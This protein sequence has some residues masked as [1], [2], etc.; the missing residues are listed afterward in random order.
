MG[1]PGK[2][3]VDY[4]SH[5][6]VAGK[7][8][9]I[10]EQRYGDKGYVFYFKLQEW[11]GRTEGHCINFAIIEDLECFLAHAR[12]KESDFNEMMSLLAKLG[13]IDEELWQQDKRV[14]SET[15]IE[16]VSHAYSKRSTAL[17][18]KPMLLSFFRG[19]N[20]V[21]VPETQESDSFRGEN[22]V[23]GV[24]N[25][26]SKVKESKEKKKGKVFN[27]PVPLLVVNQKGQKQEQLAEIVPL[28]HDPAIYVAYQKIYEAIGRYYTAE[29]K[30][31]F[32]DNLQKELFDIVGSDKAACFLFQIIGKN[33]N[34]LAQQ[35]GLT[36]AGKIK[37]ASWE[38]FIAAIHRESQIFVSE[39]RK[40][41]YG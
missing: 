5:D 37:K 28:E 23:F 34:S 29:G 24:D 17:P 4:F 9:Y 16:R 6:C 3:I 8:L 41:G 15:F 20:G 27:E 21:S 33:I 14:W 11:L 40:Q 13:E 35:N 31:I 38:Y 22:S 32:L 39:T 19:E 18:Q 1:R 30:K 7:I 2:Q 36:A 10:L 25:P 12:L 26:Q